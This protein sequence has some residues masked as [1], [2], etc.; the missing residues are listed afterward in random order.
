MTILNENYILSNGVA[1]PKLGLGTWFIDDDKAAD[2]VKTA[3]GIGYRNIDTAQAYGNERGVG[4]GIRTSGVAREELFVSTKLAAGIKD[5]DGAVA[6]IDGSLQTLGL[7][8]IDLMLIHS[9]QP[10]DDF[11]GGDY[12]EGNRQAWRA[13][14]DAYQAG[15][16]RSIGVSNFLQEDIENILS[17]ATVVPQVNQ[18][19]VH[20]GNTPADLL[21]YCAGKDI[22]VQA[23]S[24]IAHG[25]I[26]KNAEVQAMA[27]KYGVTV[28]QLCI[29]YTLQLGAV[30]L[31]KTANPEH[32]RSNAEVD[33][34]ISE[35]DMTALR[36]L[37]A[38]D[39]GDASAFPVY[40][41]K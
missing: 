17:T 21:A 33:F 35:A 1:I 39:Y 27:S 31:P 14:G 12:A 8:Y 19:L 40:S 15:K 30:S 28:P 23:Y 24:P 16:I 37:H 7:D 2:A 22:L 4:E 6:A 32:M 41:G 20:A 11:R 13:L 18:L 3:I 9:P 34:E 26:M 29:R 10:W 25:E 36:D 38:K 5:Y